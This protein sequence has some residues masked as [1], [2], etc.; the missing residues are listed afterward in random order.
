MAYWMF[1]YVM[2]LLFLMTISCQPKTTLNF[3]EIQEG[4][5]NIVD[6][7]M[8][9]TIDANTGGRITSLKLN[10]YELLTQIEVNKYAF[11]STFWA[12]AHFPGWPLPADYDRTEW[13]S[14]VNENRI[15]LTGPVIQ[16]LGLQF[17]KE[18]RF[19]SYKNSLYCTYVIYNRTDSVIK[20]A[21]WEVT[22]V[23]R[24]GVWYV[25]ADSNTFNT[26]NSLDNLEAGFKSG[27]YQCIIPSDYQGKSQKISL[28]A[29]E[30]WFVY[31]NEH[32]LFL[33]IYDDINE[34]NLAPKAGDAEFYIDGSSAYM[35]LE[36]QGMYKSLEAGD[37]LLYETKWIV[38]PRNEVF[39]SGGSP[40]GGTIAGYARKFTESF[41]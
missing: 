9:L 35:E 38:K 13:K 28:N 19:E 12:S 4:V 16:N 5:F 11:G 17:K 40:S 33:K 14:E 20:A 36:T 37:S 41:K 25:P 27:L 22:R 15:M 32:L 7:D 8:S 29:S 10:G 26:R 6:R 30:G 24:E 1:K 18:F 34:S 2:L 39:I 21:P 23:D 31:I 3:E